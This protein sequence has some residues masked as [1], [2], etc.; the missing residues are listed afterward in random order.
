[1]SEVPLYTRGGRLCCSPPD[2]SVTPWSKNRTHDAYPVRCRVPGHYEPRSER[3]RVCELK[4]YRQLRN[5]RGGRPCWHPLHPPP[6]SVSPWS[7]NRS[8]THTLSLAMSRSLSHTHAHTHTHTIP[9]PPGGRADQNQVARRTSRYSSVSRPVLCPRLLRTM[10]VVVN[11]RNAGNFQIGEGGDLA[12]IRV[13][14]LFRLF[15]R[16]FG[17]RSSWYVSRQRYRG[18]SLKINILLLGPYSR[19]M[20]RALRWSYG[21][22]SF[23]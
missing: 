1:M 17:I 23:L 21:G 16:S 10:S 15:P 12:A 19:P 5:G 3:V 18:T 20:P 2:S 14:L 6:L 9:A 8:Q 22:G 4:K 13:V 11:L 7:K